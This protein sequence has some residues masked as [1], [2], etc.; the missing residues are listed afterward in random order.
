MWHTVRICTKYVTLATYHILTLSSPAVGPISVCGLHLYFHCLLL[1]PRSRG[2]YMQCS[3]RRRMKVRNNS[4]LIT[5][6]QSFN[7]FIH[8]FLI[9][10]R[11]FTRH[12]R[13]IPKSDIYNKYKFLHTDLDFFDTS[14][15]SCEFFLLWFTPCKAT[16]TKRHG[17]TRKRSTKRFKHTVSLFR[18]TL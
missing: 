18:K 11:N 8:S 2:C 16:A 9:F 14:N 3:W 17:V 1:N 12:G 10:Q 4:L 5:L 6:N 7:K 13:H 15:S